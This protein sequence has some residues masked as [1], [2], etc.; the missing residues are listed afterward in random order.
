MS[1]EADVVAKRCGRR[2]PPGELTGHEEQVAP[3]AR[4]CESNPLRCRVR[5]KALGLACGGSRANDFRL[6]ARLKNALGGNGFRGN[7]LVGNGLGSH[8]LCGGLGN[9]VLCPGGHLWMPSRRSHLHFLDEPDKLRGAS[10]S[11][12]RRSLLG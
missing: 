2:G 9:L 5:T 7:A 6:D 3:V 10:L 8:R 12:S 4:L 11:E 1:A